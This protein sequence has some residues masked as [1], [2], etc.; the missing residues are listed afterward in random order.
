MHIFNF[1]YF[2]EKHYVILPSI[3]F[4]GL[5]VMALFLF[6]SLEIEEKGAIKRHLSL[7]SKGTEGF[8][9]V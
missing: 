8:L 3:T 2:F 1:W 7:D 5:N 4:K 9:T 6:I